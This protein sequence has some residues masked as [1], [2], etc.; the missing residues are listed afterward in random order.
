MEVQLIR[1]QGY[2]GG[3]KHAI[4]IALKAKEENK[5]KKIYILGMLVHNQHVINDLNNN[6]IITL[7]GD[8]I[9]EINSL[10][11]GDV[12]IFT[13]HGHDAKYDEIAK[14]KGLI[15][16][17]ATCPVVKNIMKLI[18]EKTDGNHQ[19]I[20][21]GQRGHKETNAALSISDKVSLYDTKLLI[22]YQFITDNSPIVINQTT[23]NYFEIQNIYNDIKKHFSGAIILGE[24]CN[25]TR[26]RQQA[27]ANIEKDSDLILIVGDVK[28]S[29]TNKLFDIAKKMYP[30]T[31][32][33]LVSSIDDVKKINLKDKKKA[34]ISSGASTPEFIVEEIYN[35]L[36]TL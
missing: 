16:Y 26:L 31:D 10:N 20:Y 27:I 25:A 1:P 23:L 5:D 29:N 15:I 11:P 13:A 18:K 14:N 8:E 19:V 9:E 4:E 12:L 34:A 3:V 36:S 30:N 21:I 33:Y 24:I 2:C 7:L 17:D 6:G 28:S 32:S 22:N 35:Y